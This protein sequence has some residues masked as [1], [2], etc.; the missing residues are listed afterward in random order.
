[1]EL[2]DYIEL[3]LLAREAALNNGMSVL[4]GMFAYL[5]ACYFEG[6]NFGWPLLL[7][8]TALYSIFMYFSVNGLFLNIDAT[9]LLAAEME[10]NFPAH[11]YP[12]FRPDDEWLKW[13]IP[14]TFVVAWILQYREGAGFNTSA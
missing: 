1:M 13:L 7:G 14:L 9:F 8:L 2:R 3:I 10:K 5:I 12:S 4:A 6:K 11:G